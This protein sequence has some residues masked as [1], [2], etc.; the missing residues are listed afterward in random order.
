MGFTHLRFFQF[1]NLSDGVVE[2][3][4]AQVFLV[5]E[6]GQGKS[7]FLESIY[8]LSYGSGFRARKD[9]EMCRIGMREM[10]VDG[11]FC[12]DAGATSVEI[13]YTDGQKRIRVDHTPLTDRR[14][15]V[16]RIPSVVFRHDDM[17]FLTGPPP[18]Q[19]FFI[20]QTLSMYRPSYIDDLRR[21]RVVLKNRN[22]AIKDDLWDVVSV[23]DHELAVIG[24]TITAYRSAVI[25][26]FNAVFAAE[27]QAIS[28]LDHPVVLDYRPSWR[29]HE[30]HGG[31][32]GGGGIDGGQPTAGAIAGV[33]ADLERRRETDRA[34]RTTTS[35]PHRDRILF[36][37]DERDFVSLA[38]TGQ[39]RLTALVLRV[40][41]A[42]FFAH[43]TGR[44][45]LLLLDD[46]LLELDP[47]RRQRFI[48]RLPQSEQR[49]FYLSPG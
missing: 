45:P 21:Y 5:G 29:S 23:Y 42:R 33:I 32:E 13:R 27:F 31:G 12:T 49:F 35:G 8:L 7:N 2:P 4:S 19:R 28:G 41:Q 37:Y 18:M 22:R 10:A 17:A 6:N 46:V 47:T 36:R 40:A 30:G 1:R 39:Q 38:S 34:M 25:A 24:L 43:Q 3:T 20:D 44:R 9:G 11:T 16:S 26:R 14:D 48:A 15:L